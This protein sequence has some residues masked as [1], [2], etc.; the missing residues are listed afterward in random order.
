MIRTTCVATVAALLLTA[1]GGDDDE[2]G[3]FEISSANLSGTVAGAPF[4]F[5]SGRA[6][7]PFE[8]GGD[9]SI[10]LT[11]EEDDDPCVSFGLPE[12]AIILL[13]SDGTPEDEPL[14]LANN[15][16]FAYDGSQNDIATRG[17]KV[18]HGIEDGVLRGGLH[19]I[20]DD[21]V[22]DGQFA[23]PICEN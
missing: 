11:Q 14:S 16:T 3:G 18:I 10:V 13:R 2:G 19:A 17:R 8:P 23:I 5:R 6:S 9:Y 20:M 1:C 12:S 21:H 4:V 22:V 15:I 7:M